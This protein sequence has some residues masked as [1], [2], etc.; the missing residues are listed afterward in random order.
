MKRSLIFCL[1][2]ALAVLSQPW[3][4]AA[5][6]P[7][8]SAGEYAIESNMTMPHLDEMRRMVSRETRCIAAQ[9][10]RALFPVMRQPALNGCQF[11][12]PKPVQDSIHY[13]LACESARV[14][15]GTLI[16]EAKPPTVIGNLAIK[17]GGKNMTFAQR[18]V[19]TRQGACD[20]KR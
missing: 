20:A 7:E 4:T 6:P 1:L 5:A 8:L 13:V 2:P 18:V 16:L 14:A 19:A 9:D 11:D 17:M 10:I 12:F 15:T 3:T